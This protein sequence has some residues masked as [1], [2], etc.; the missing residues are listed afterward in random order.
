MGHIK[1]GSTKSCGCLN[2]EAIQERS[3]KHGHSSGGKRTAEYQAW[4]D[5]KSRCYNPNVR[6]YAE[7]GGRGIRMCDRWL[8]SSEAFLKDMGPKPSPLHSLDRIDNDGNY[9][10]GVAVVGTLSTRARSIRARKPHVNSASSS[11]LWRSACERAG[12][13]TK[14]SR[15]RSSL[16]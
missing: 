14:Q 12:Q 4:K 11:I 2:L 15:R 16:G 5:A 3:T 6:N 8:H 13:Q 10:P 7:Y 1:S 9:E